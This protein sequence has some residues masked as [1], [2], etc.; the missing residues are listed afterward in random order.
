MLGEICFFFV[1]FSDLKIHNHR[2][3]LM[4]VG[5]LDCIGLLIIGYHYEYYWRDVCFLR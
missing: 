4:I 1:S 3:L 5:A 2:F